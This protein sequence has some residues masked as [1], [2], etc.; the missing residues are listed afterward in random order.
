MFWY[1]KKEITSSD[2]IPVDFYID[3]FSTKIWQNSSV[4]IMDLNVIL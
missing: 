2:L 4:M 3:Y 1:F